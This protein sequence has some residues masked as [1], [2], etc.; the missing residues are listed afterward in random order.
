MKMNDNLV[1]ISG[2]S[3]TGKS[4]SL[5]NIAAPE[6]VIYLN[7]ENNKKLPFRGKFK[8]FGITDPVQV[9]QAFEEAEK[10]DDVH[11]IVVDSLT[12]M[13]DM[14]ESYYVLNSSNTM[15]AWGD[16]A[17][18]FKKLMS[19][20]VAESTKNV[21]FIA[22]TTDI[23]N[24]AEMAMETLVK[25]KGSLMNQGIESYFSTVVSTKK[26][27]LKSLK[28]YESDLLDITPD[29]EEL[30]FKYVFQTRITKDTVNERMR[31][32]LSMWTTNES[33]TDNNIQLVID[34]LHEY[35]V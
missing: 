22:H 1:L 27:N 30:G 20:Y 25:V 13:M 3:A 12:Y 2:K 7:C 16:Y 28:K 29:E 17:Q 10:M 14:Y 9:Y 23:M 24:D 32:P 26:V 15:K 34:R 21:I 11:T 8:E 19:K 5:M 33:F 35:Y 18:F 31:A 6:G 4:A